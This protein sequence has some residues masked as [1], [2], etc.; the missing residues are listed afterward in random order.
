MVASTK[1]NLLTA[2]NLFLHT[3]VLCVF[4]V[5][6]LAVCPVRAQKWQLVW[7]D[8][9]NFASETSVDAAKWTA[10]T[11]GT[12]WGNNERQYYTASTRN[13][14]HDGRGALVITA[15]K[16]KLPSS[17]KCWYG[18][19]QYTSAR[20]ITKG[21][22][23][24]TYGRFEARIKLP[25]GQG[26]WPAFWLLGADI[27]TVGWSQCGEIDVMENI[28]REPNI[29]HGTL[30]GPGYSGAS[31]IGAAYT[32]PNGKRSADDYHVYAVEWEPDVIRW[33]VDNNLYHTLTPAS[34]PNEAKWVFDHPFFILLNVAVGGRWPGEPDATTIFPQKMSID[35][36]RVYRR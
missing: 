12:G 4:A 32:L 13:A 33:Y 26:I 2:R 34:L 7:S 14:Y 3:R 9:F 30:H 15:I 29:V 18:E 24:Q 21:K 28:G 23:A 10:E 11:G 19:C 17:S 35:Y 8:E 6:L 5:L 20:L 36:V 31:S 27:D 1:L 16:E 25:Y 22:F